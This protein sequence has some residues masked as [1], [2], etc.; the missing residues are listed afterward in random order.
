MH[1]RVEGREVWKMASCRFCCMEVVVR[2]PLSVRSL[3]FV[4]A[5]VNYR[6]PLTS[7]RSKHTQD[8]RTKQACSLGSWLKT[9]LTV[10]CHA[11][12]TLPLT[13]SLDPPTTHAMQPVH[14]VTRPSSRVH[15]LPA[16]T[17]DN[18]WVGRQ[19][20]SSIERTGQSKSTCTCIHRHGSL[21]EGE[22]TCLSSEDRYTGT[23]SSPSSI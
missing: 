10:A 2:R 21:A 1:Q 8:R 18:D 22:D 13:S 12:S 7:C 4:S 6:L 16:S 3:L 11:G 23:R 5:S 14:H 19:G 15:G 9:S 17:L 20:T